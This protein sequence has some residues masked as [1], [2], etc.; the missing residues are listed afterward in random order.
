MVAIATSR[1]LK[2]ANGVVNSES[3]PRNIQTGKVGI[4]PLSNVKH[5]SCVPLL[6]ITAASVVVHVAVFV[7]AVVGIV[8]VVDIVAAAAVVVAVVSTGP[9]PP[10]TPDATPEE[11]SL[12]LL[13]AFSADVPASFLVSAPATLF[14]DA[15]TTRR[16]KQ[17]SLAEANPASLI[18]VFDTD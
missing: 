9:R 6:P 18:A 16:R 10:A 17:V 15:P 14:V 13:D 4:Q 7:A 3:I 8:T 1:D 11:D 5:P 12:P 2:R